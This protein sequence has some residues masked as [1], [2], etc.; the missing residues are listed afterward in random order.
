MNNRKS[1]LYIIIY[2]AIPSLILSQTN[3]LGMF[4][5]G[6]LFHGDI[7]YQNAEL[8]LL[9][10]KKSIGLEFKRNLNYH[11]G[12]KISVINGEIYAD[13]KHNP[14][15]FREQQNLKFRSKIT[16]IGILFELNFRPY[17]SR[18]DEYNSTP[19]VFT[20]LTNFYFNPQ[21]K[22]NGNWYNLRP[23]KTEGQGSDAYPTRDLYRLNGLS[24]PV[25]IGYKFNAYKVLT[26]AFNIGWRI[27]FIDYIDDVSTT[28]VDDA[29][30]NS[31]GQDLSNPSNHQFTTGFQRGDPY[32][33]DK[34][35]F[36]GVSVL[37]SF[38]DKSKDCKDIIY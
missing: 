26:I 29:I 33:N 23:L 17:L 38:K 28:Y 18:D 31:L 8:S 9:K 24:I 25:G 22:N 32:D 35:G 13:S 7:G 34:Y 10:S 16:E 30:L 15:I 21:S 27:T 19:F 5:G 11:F 20:G 4:I 6:S 36:F 2:L 1:I 14:N 12:V 37:Y 3:E